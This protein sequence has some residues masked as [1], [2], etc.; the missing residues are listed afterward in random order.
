MHNRQS[1]KES[2][3]DSE[4]LKETEVERLD[5]ELSRAEQAQL[6]QWV[7]R[8]LGDAEPWTESELPTCGHE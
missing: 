5:R 6:L 2:I 8:D 7:V 3:M 1:T 4:R